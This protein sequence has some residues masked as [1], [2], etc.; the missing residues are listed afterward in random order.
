MEILFNEQW[1][2]Y[3]LKS[4]NCNFKNRTY[5]GSTN[6]IKRRI[7]QHNKEIK[8]GAKATS[9]MCPNEIYCI[10]SGFKDKISV[11]RCEWLLKHPEGKKSNSYRG[12]IGRIK[13]L[14]YLVSQSEKWK[15]RSNTDKISIWI[16]KEYCEYLQIKDFDENVEINL[17]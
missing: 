16:K 5:V 12:I 15:S 17:I 2:C 11:L 13:G 14:S 7:R 6:N 10:V 8:G 1:V 4:N 3:I 9:M